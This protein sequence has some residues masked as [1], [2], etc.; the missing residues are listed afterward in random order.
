MTLKN[1]KKQAD[2]QCLLKRIGL[3]PSSAVIRLKKNI[4]F[5]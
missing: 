2:S 1:S 5:I 3:D 4:L